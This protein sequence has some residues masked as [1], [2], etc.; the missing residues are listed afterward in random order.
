MPRIAIPFPETNLHT[1]QQNVPIPTLKAMLK[2]AASKKCVLLFTDVAARGIDIPDVDWVLQFDPPQDP[3][4]YIHR[5]GRTARLDRE[6]NEKLSLAPSEDTYCTPISFSY[7][8]AKFRNLENWR[9][10]GTNGSTVNDARLRLL[11]IFGRQKSSPELRNMD[12][13][14]HNVRTADVGCQV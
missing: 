6:G 11:R 12:A 4:V 2:F 10:N 1:A 9:K 14:I 3:D 13:D 8:D 7:E 5:V